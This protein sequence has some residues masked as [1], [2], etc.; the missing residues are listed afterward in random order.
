MVFWAL[1]SFFHYFSSCCVLFLGW[2]SLSFFLQCLSLFLFS[3]SI[4]TLH[5]IEQGEGKPVCSTHKGY[6]FPTECS[7]AMRKRNKRKNI[8]WTLKARFRKIY[9][10]MQWTGAGAQSTSCDWGRSTRV[11]LTKQ[12]VRVFPWQKEGYYKILF[13][14]VAAVEL[15]KNS[16]AV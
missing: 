16:V 13:I 8:I 14:M 7:W 11:F 10:Y 9:N 12:A 6:Q 5:D 2:Q 15:Y 1:K 3:F 4:G